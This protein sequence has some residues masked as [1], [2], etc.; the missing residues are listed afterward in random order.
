MSTAR[1]EGNDYTKAKKENGNDFFKITWPIVKKQTNKNKS[2]D[3]AFFGKEM[4]KS[5]G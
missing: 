4:A 3:F 1:T 2:C 5:Q